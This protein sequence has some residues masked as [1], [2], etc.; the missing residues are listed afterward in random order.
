MSDSTALALIIASFFPGG[1]LVFYLTKMANDIS[2]EIVAGVVRGSPAST[3]YRWILLYQTWL[4]YA[5]A[6]MGACVFV[7]ALNVKIAVQATDRGVEAVAY[8]AA[9][10]FALI[11]FSWLVGAVSELIYYRSVLRQAEAD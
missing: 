1:F 8:L 4:G 6:A 7:A 10:F 3:T 11:A 5:L 2:H 9:F